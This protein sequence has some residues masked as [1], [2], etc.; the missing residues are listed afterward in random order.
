MIDPDNLLKLTPLN[1]QNPENVIELDP[2]IVKGWVAFPDGTNLFLQG[3]PGHN[4]LTV[5]ELP[6]EIKSQLR[7]LREAYALLEYDDVPEM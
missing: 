1:A 2:W 5:K 7:K 6:D 4:V 3:L